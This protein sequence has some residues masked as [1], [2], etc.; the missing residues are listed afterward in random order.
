MHVD[1]FIHQKLLK[2]VLR[3]LL[4]ISELRVSIVHHF[5]LLLRLRYTVVFKRAS[6]K[7]LFSYIYLV[8]ALSL[9]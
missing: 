8:A 4:A 7:P 9:N 2:V 1:V 6:E 5:C 3:M